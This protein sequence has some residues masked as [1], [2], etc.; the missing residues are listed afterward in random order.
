[1][2]GEKRTEVE[3]GRQRGKKQKTYL[4]LGRL[5]LLDLLLVE[6]RVG[7]VARVV[8]DSVSVLAG[9]VLKTLRHCQSLLETSYTGR[10]E[11]AYTASQRTPYS[12]S[13]PIFVE[14]V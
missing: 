12:C 2:M 5:E 7:L 9:E 10:G 4:T 8:R 1:M 14:D 3:R 6:V 13:K 11:A